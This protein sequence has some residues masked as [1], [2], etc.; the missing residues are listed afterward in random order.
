MDLS[1]Q[2]RLANKLNKKFDYEFIDVPSSRPGH[3]LRYALD[4]SVLESLGWK[5]QKSN[6][7]GIESVIDWYLENSNWL[8][9]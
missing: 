7:E 2:N 5:A 6:I 4:N 9:Y 1:K 8:N 3:D